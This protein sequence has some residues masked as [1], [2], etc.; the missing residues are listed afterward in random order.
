MAAPEL[1]PNSAYTYFGSALMRY[2]QLRARPAKQ[3][4]PNAEDYCFMSNDFEPG[5]LSMR[6]AGSLC[7]LD[8]VELESYCDSEVGTDVAT[9]VLYGSKSSTNNPRTV[10]YYQSSE[11]LE[12]EVDGSEPE[13]ANLEELQ[14]VLSALQRLEMAGELA[15]ALK[16]EEMITS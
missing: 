2:V 5:M 13:T 4:F 9:L 1:Y 6:L 15:V 8:A 3:P 14:Y 16:K 11:G 10:K 12:Q 7:I